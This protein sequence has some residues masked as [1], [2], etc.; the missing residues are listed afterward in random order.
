MFEKD[1]LTGLVLAVKSND[2]TRIEGFENISG[3]YQN[4]FDLVTSNIPFGAISVYDPA[5][6]KKGPVE[7]RAVNQIHNYFF[8]KSLEQA[9]PGGL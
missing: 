7:A 4:H 1:L 8:L 9:K 6:Q 2:R 3:R 5:F